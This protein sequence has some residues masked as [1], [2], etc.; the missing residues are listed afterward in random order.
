VEDY[1]LITIPGEPMGKQRPRIGKG[2]TYTPTKTVNY[3]TLVKLTIQQ[4]LQKWDKFD[5]LKGE[6]SAE[7][8]A[9]YSIPKS[10]SKKKQKSMLDGEIRPT[11]KPDSDNVAKIILD[12]LNGIAYKDDSQIVDLIVHKFFGNQPR[13]EILIKS[14]VLK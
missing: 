7:I 6:I 14:E 4:K 12:A 10:A 3:E 8:T 1:V 2:F 11:K 13:V 9:F 5:P